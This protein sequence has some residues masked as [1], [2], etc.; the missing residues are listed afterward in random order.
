MA[1]KP[2]WQDPEGLEIIRTIISKRIPQWKEGL[3]PSQLEPIALILDG[4]DVLCT[5]ATGSGKSALFFVP[6][7]VHL[8]L[9]T[10][11]EMY[12]NHSKQA[13]HLPVGVVVT[14]TKGLSC[15]LVS[16]SNLIV[17][18]LQISVG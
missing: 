13:H 7:L 8:E 10:N 16:P 4:E 9:S 5:M 14:P 3:R 18:R 17:L 11:P 15:N 2:L 12:P 1:S 6:I